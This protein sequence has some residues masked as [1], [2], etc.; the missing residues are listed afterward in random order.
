M[1]DKRLRYPEVGRARGGTVDVAVRTAW[2]VAGFPDLT[3]PV[4]SPLGRE[5]LLDRIALGVLAV[6]A[7]G[8]APLRSARRA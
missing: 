7:C 6:L 3:H 4:T 1:I 8:R 2:A 5:R